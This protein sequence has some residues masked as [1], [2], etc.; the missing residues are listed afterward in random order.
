MPELS[1]IT[2]T[3]AFGNYRR[4]EISSGFASSAVTWFDGLGQLDCTVVMDSDEGTC[5]E[6]EK[7]FLECERPYLCGCL[8]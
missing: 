3:L 2:M 8:Q 4:Q 1:V 5:S 7:Y 6:P